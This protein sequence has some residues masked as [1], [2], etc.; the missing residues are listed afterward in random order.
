MPIDWMHNSE[1]DVD[2]AAHQQVLLWQEKM[3]AKV[4]TQRMDLIQN[5]TTNDNLSLVVDFSYVRWIQDATPIKA[6]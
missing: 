2:L 3:L 5:T 4:M 1:K 6:L